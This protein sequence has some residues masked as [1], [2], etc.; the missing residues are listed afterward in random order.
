[1]AS[2]DDL[3][4]L[5]SVWDQTGV[6]LKRSAMA[7]RLGHLDI[8]REDLAGWIDF[9]EVGYRRVLIHRTSLFE[10][11]LLCWRSGQRSPIHDHAGSTCGVRVIAGTATETV[12]AASPCGRLYPVRTKRLAAGSV[13]VNHDA[14]IH[15]LANLARP[16]E[17]LITLHIYSPP[18]AGVRTYSIS[19]TVLADHDHLAQRRPPDL[20]R[21]I[22]MDRPHARSSNTSRRASKVA[23]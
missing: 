15:Q 19:E 21:P 3:G 16:G 11:L 4:N 23:R 18:L 5:L 6:P 13:C 12:Y 2:A 8:R 20:A 17:D 22:R 7:R 14:E 1:M 9:S 10:V